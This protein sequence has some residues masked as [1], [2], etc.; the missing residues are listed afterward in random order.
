M[1]EQNSSNNPKT[2]WVVSPRTGA[3]LAADILHLLYNLN[4]S[5]NAPS[6]FKNKAHITWH[7]AFIIL[8]S[9][10]SPLLS[11]TLRWVHACLLTWFPDIKGRAVV[12]CVGKSI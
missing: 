6:A 3:A 9:S 1:Y 10:I 4:C 8:V 11:F 12:V 7:C 5:R 2:M